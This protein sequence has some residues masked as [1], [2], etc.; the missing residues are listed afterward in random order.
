MQLSDEGYP[1]VDLTLGICRRLGALVPEEWRY[2]SRTYSTVRIGLHTLAAGYRAV[3][4][5]YGSQAGWEAATAEVS[6]W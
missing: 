1:R 4:C 6:A 2:S 3:V 5:H